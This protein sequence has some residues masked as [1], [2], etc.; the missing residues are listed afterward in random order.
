M[1]GFLIIFVPNCTGIEDP[2]VFQK[3]KSF[4]FGEKHTFAFTTGFFEKNLPSYGFSVEFVD[5]TPH[6]TSKLTMIDG[7]ELVVVARKLG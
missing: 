6:G 3:K 5:V 1:G 7:A 2:V 4:A